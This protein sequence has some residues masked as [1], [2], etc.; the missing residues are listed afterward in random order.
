ML[1]DVALQPHVGRFASSLA[2]LIGMFSRQAV[3][4]SQETLHVKTAVGE[5]GRP[6]TIRKAVR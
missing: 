2:G 6:A 3:L 1:H 4:K 5:K